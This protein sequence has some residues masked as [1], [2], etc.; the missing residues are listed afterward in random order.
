MNPF[1]CFCVFLLLFRDCT[2]DNSIEDYAELAIQF[3]Y[4]TLF[5]AALPMAS[6]FSFIANIVEN[7]NDAWK[8][9][10]WY[11][12]PMP[13]SAED[14]GV[15]CVCLNAF[16]LFALDC[17][18]SAPFNILILLMHNL[19]FN[20]IFL[21]LKISFFAGFTGKIFSSSLQFSPS[22]RMQRS[23]CSRCPLLTSSLNSPAIGSIS[24][25]N[26]LALHCRFV[27]Y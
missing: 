22:S 21:Q 14:I 27:C 19:F 4:A 5:V 7:K 18:L 25:S 11:Q 24:V 2:H 8:L 17:P 20:H 15:W 1:V 10:N 26:G 13:S 12:R 3:G 6:F 16:T 9:L 23:L